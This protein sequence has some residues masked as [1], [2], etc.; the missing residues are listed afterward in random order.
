MQFFGT[1]L[2]AGKE[3]G[4]M[5]CILLSAAFVAASVAGICSWGRIT[6][7]A[8]DLHENVPVQKK[9]NSA[10][11]YSSAGAA[12]GIALIPVVREIRRSAAAD[13]VAWL[14]GFAAVLLTGFI[15]GLAIGDIRY[16]RFL[17]K[18]GSVK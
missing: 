9:G 2:C 14:F 13:I 3:S 15:A 17:Q 8:I 4:L 6:M 12:V 1:A 10:S 18:K 11:A 5:S 16:I 7:K